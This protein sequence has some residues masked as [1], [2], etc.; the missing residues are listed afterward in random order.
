[1]TRFEVD[2]SGKRGKVVRDKRS[3]TMMNQQDSS[4]EFK[5]LDSLEEFI[6]KYP[7]RISNF[8][9]RFMA[10]VEMFS[11]DALQAKQGEDRSNVKKRMKIGWKWIK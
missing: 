11:S 6:A 3:K 9:S 5:K 10:M 8:I 2:D 1:M 4:P 7:N